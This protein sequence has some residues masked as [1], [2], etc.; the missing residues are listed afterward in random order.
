MKL[1]ESSVER[2]KRRVRYKLKKSNNLLPRLSVFR[3]GK[4][5]YAQ[6]IDDLKGMTIVAANSLEKGFKHLALKSTSNIE[7]ASQIGKTIAQRAL[8]K[9]VTAVVFDRGGYLFHGRVKALA[10]A[11][12]ASGLK[13]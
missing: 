2:R 12:K 10:E 4:Y 8:E 6:I 11:A 9:G 3:S 1:R 5:I 7:A 13:I